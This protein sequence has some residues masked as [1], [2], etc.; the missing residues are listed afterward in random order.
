MKLAAIAFS[1]QGKELAQ[2][3]G[4][5]HLHWQ[6]SVSDG[7]GPE[8]VELKTWTKACF[9]DESLDGLIFVGAAGIAVRAITPHIKTKMKDPA[10]I[11]IDEGGRFVIPLLAGHVGGA[12]AIAAELAQVLGATPVITTATDGRGL[13]AVDTWAKSQDLTIVNPKEI[14]TVSAALL[15]GKTVKIYSDDP[16]EGKLPELVEITGVKDEAT[17]VITASQSGGSALHLAPPVITM[18]IGARRGIPEKKVTAAFDKAVRE[19]GIVPEAIESV[20]SI[21]LKKDEKGIIDF[22]R[23]RDL[24]FITHTAQEL[25]AVTGSL[26]VGD[27]ISPSAFVKSVTGVD[28]VC[29]RAA[30]MTGGSLILKKFVA[31]GVTIAFAK[32]DNYP[33]S[34]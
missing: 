31:D 22:C 17:V 20:H 4:K 33:L 24:P 21:D 10:V 19:A 7:F 32:D 30:L 9:D 6:F 2:S 26:T 34:F 11:V 29:E 3:L 16:I 12:N 5:K 28:N 15:A 13:F 18:G 27:E 8:K 23:R 1:Q 14:V 25:E